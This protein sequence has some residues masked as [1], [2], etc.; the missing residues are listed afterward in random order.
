VK[1]GG[2]KLGGSHVMIKFNDEQVAKL[3]EKFMEDF[4]RPSK[5][6]TDEEL[7]DYASGSISEAEKESLDE[8]LVACGSCTEAV[9]LMIK[10]AERWDAGAGKRILANA[11][12][13][14]KRTAVAASTSSE[15]LKKQLVERFRAAIQ[16]A[17]IPHLVQYAQSTVAPYSKWEEGVAV[18]DITYTCRRGEDA[19]EFYFYAPDQEFINTSYAVEMRSEGRSDWTWQ[20]ETTFIECETVPAMKASAYLP[21][22]REERLEWPDDAR[23]VKLT[24][25]Q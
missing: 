3:D 24:P 4:S 22:D 5:C 6:P 20:G 18:G 10:A 15:Q 19:V 9:A 7:L 16:R 2:A 23:V 21:I 17:L 8:H 1:L 13:A 14:L 11:R 12:P 25:K